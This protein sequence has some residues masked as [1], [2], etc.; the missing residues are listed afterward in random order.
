MTSSTT[1]D[2]IFTD[3][4]RFKNIDIKP[5]MNSISDQMKMKTPQLQKQK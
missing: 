1:T 4:T 2:N 5:I 3:C